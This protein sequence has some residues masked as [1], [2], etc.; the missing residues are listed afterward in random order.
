MGKHLKLPTE[1]LRVM[2]NMTEEL[3]DQENQTLYIKK[4]TEDPSLTK[5]VLILHVCNAHDIL[6]FCHTGITCK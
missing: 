2:E 5:N 1:S 4:L 6:Y 3:A